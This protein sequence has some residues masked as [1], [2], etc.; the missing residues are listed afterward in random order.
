MQTPLRIAIA[1][2]DRFTRELLQGLI[3][4]L[5]HEV[6]AVADNGLS[7]IDQCAK[8]RPDV[9]IT[10]NLMSGVSGVNAALEIYK[11][12]PIPIILVSGYCDPTVVRDAE[13]KHILVYLVKPVSQD[14]LGAALSK[15]REELMGPTHR[16][17]QNE[18]WVEPLESTPTD[19]RKPHTRQPR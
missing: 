2:D 17:I 13:E 18:V 15:C 9:V 6:V 12:R 3:P 5:G 19:S 8:T 11:A 4:K 10:D 1:D 7:L 14:H 16:D